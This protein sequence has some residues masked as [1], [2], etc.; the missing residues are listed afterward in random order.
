MEEKKLWGD[1]KVQDAEVIEGV[2]HEGNVRV[3]KHGTQLALKREHLLELKRCQD[4]IIYFAENYVTINIGAEKALIKLWDIQK[5]ILISFVNNQR[6]IVNASR[7]TS[8]STLVRIYIL[9]RLITTS[10]VENV[11]IVTNKFAFSKTFLKELKESYEALP[12]F[13]KKNVHTYASEKVVFCKSDGSNGSQVFIQANGPD[14]LR[15]NALTC[16][17][18]DE[19]AFFNRN[20]K[21]PLDEMVLESVTPALDAVDNNKDNTVK[22]SFLLTSTPYGRQGAFFRIYH[23]AKECEELLEKY[24]VEEVKAMGKWTPWTRKEVL[25]SDHPSRDQEWYENK[26]LELG[27]KGFSVEYGGSFDLGDNAPTILTKES[28]DYHSTNLE[29][30]IKTASKSLQFNHGDIH[31]KSLKIWEFPVK[32]HIYQAGVDISGGVGECYSTIQVLDITDLN[33]I[34]QVAEYRN[35][36]IMPASFAQVCVKLFQSYNDCYAFIE[37]NNHGMEV[38]PLISDTYGYKKLMTYHTNKPTLI[39]WIQNG[40]YGVHSD[41]NSKKNAIRNLRHF[42]NHEYRMK[43]IKIRSEDLLKELQTFQKKSSSNGNETWSKSSGG[44]DDLVDALYWAVLALSPLV[45]ERYYNLEL[46]NKYAED[47]K[48]IKIVS[49]KSTIGGS[50]LNGLYINQPNNQQAVV[51]TDN[52]NVSNHQGYMMDDDPSWLNEL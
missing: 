15:G 16:A 44:F 9:W 48:P 26:I 24:S 25:W 40:V 22:S 45:V 17:V 2:F 6:V 1:S 41:S 4:D 29:Q 10:S 28:S 50:N 39:K 49:P 27:S 5:D 47:T 33:D 31:D 23:E 7:Q 51:Y 11:G 20:S 52:M 19:F 46:P 18:C 38:C 21:D 36:T 34:R 35:N 32:D 30:P 3:P 14:A 8:K 12:Y 37:K 42:L 43:K 13:M